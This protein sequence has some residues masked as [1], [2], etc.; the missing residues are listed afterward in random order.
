MKRVIFL[1]IISSIFKFFGC[2]SKSGNSQ[3]QTISEKTELD[4]QIMKSVEEFKN[5][6]IY[7]KLTAEIIES[8]SDDE[9]LQVVFDNLSEQL[10]KDYRKEYEFI[11]TKFNS[12]QQAIFL[13]WWLEGEVNNGG[14]NQY[15]TNSSGQYAEM[16]PQLLEKMGAIRF[17]ELTDRANKIYKSNFEEITKEQD[18]TIEGFSKSYENNPLNDLDSE[19][20]EL[21]KEEDLYKKQIEFIRANKEDFIN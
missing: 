1:I 5:R 12:S 9:L 15:Y 7:K 6:K 17:A 18:G 3:N 14:F 8:T 16:V 11:T 13:S 21:Y 19:F 20:Y 4:E 2:T 10:P